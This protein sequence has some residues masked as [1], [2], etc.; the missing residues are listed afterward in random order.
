[1]AQKPLPQRQKDAQTIKLNIGELQEYAEC[2]TG[3]IKV[4]IPA[5]QL[6]A[7]VNPTTGGFIEQDIWM[8]EIVSTI[9]GADTEKLVKNI[10]IKLLICSRIPYFVIPSPR[11]MI[12]PL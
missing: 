11:M 5:L 10:L 1:M 6:K 3:G 7:I 4:K 12:I 9:R 8:D 2:S